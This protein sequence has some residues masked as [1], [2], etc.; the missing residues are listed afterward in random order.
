LTVKGGISAGFMFMVILSWLPIIGPILIGIVAGI[1][2][3][4]I[5]KVIIN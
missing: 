1:I 4:M 5:Y 2:L 3:E